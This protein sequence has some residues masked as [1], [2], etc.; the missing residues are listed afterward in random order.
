MA[1]NGDCYGVQEKGYVLRNGVIYRNTSKS[2][3]EDL[4]IYEDG[5]F[6]IIN[7]S[8]VTLEE[9]KEKG[10][11][12]VISFGPALINNGVISVD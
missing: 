10:A 2:N 7:E 4:V 3:Q 1:I 12:Q 9:L 6:E 11:Y 8:Y 5:T